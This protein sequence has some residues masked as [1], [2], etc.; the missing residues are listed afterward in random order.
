MTEPGPT[1]VVCATHLLAPWLLNALDAE[2][3]GVPDDVSVVVYGDSD[4]AR[5][6][7]P[8]LSV[9]SHDTYAEGFDLAIGLLDAIAGTATRPVR[10]VE[11]RFVERGTCGPAVGF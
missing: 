3:R 11:A 2:E 1:A 9:V 4:W 10:T 6:H 5:A 7:Q 8:P